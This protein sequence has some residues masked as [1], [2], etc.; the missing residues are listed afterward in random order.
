MY[1]FLSDAGFVLN[2]TLLVKYKY[3]RLTRVKLLSITFSTC[4]KDIIVV[5]IICHAD[6]IVLYINISTHLII[7]SWC[8][9]TISR[10][11]RIWLP[12]WLCLQGR[13]CSGVDSSGSQTWCWGLWRTRRM[14]CSLHQHDISSTHLLRMWYLLVFVVV[15]VFHW[16]FFL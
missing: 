6:N 12:P 15:F 10:V 13:W 11:S 16:S 14:V 9:Q 1:I 7:R 3:T 4:V 8:S 5:S 2:N